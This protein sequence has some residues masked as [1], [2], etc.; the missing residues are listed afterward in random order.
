MKNVQPH[1]KVSTPGLKEFGERGLLIEGVGGGGEDSLVTTFENY[2]ERWADQN[3]TKQIHV[4][5]N[6]R[7]LLSI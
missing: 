4:C 7:E 2:C 1:R 6:E 5:K 3:W